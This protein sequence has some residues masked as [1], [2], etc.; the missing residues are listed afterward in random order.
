MPKPFPYMNASD[1]KFWPFATKLSLL[2]TIILTLGLLLLFGVS[3]ATIKWPTDKLETPVLIGIAI[4]ALLPIVLALIDVIITRGGSIEFKGVKIDFAQLAEKGVSTFT[5]PVN[6]GIRGESADDSNTADIIAVLKQTATC[7][8]IVIDLEDG[9]AWWET[10]LLV[11]LSGANRIHK[12]D[13]IVFIG[14]EAE[15]KECFYGWASPADLYPF[16]ERIPIYKTFLRFAES[17]AGQWALVEPPEPPAGDT[18]QTLQAP[19]TGKKAGN[20]QRMVLEK[21]GER[22]SFLQEQVLQMELGNKIEGSAEGARRISHVRLDDLFGPVLKKY[23]ID[24]DWPEEQ[25]MRSFLSNDAPYMAITQGG[26]YISIVSRMAIYNQM[27]KGL[28]DK[29]QNSKPT[30]RC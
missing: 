22:N 10:R 30:P 13:K 25:Q 24:Q 6:M 23:S 5:L 7:G 8:T 21:S 27:M 17:I 29:K 2:W 4:I 14:M 9:Q 12:P 18:Q 1:N 15:Q 11:L 16:M 3:R 19:S 26:K 28:V 20:Y